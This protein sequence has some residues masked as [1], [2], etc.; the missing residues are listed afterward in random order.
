MALVVF[1]LFSLLQIRKTQAAVSPVK[2]EVV[3]LFADSD[4]C[5]LTVTCRT[6]KAHLNATFECRH[7][8]CTAQDGGELSNADWH[9][10]AF[11]LNSS[12]VCR[13]SN[14]VSEMKE[15]KALQQVCRQHVPKEISS[16]T[17]IWIPLVFG[18]ALG[19]ALIR[20]ALRRRE[21][22][23]TRT[24]EGCQEINLEPNVYGNDIDNGTSPNSTYSLVGHHKGPSETM[25][26]QVLRPAKLPKMLEADPMQVTGQN[27]N[28]LLAL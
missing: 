17:W 22:Q 1:L 27:N 10:A 14:Q 16:F 25:Y 15:A 19:L 24:P 18:L 8:N 3:S 7:A 20:F 9:L 26:A 13:H 23:A 11:I 21:R 5:N 6:N 12:I 28:P 4:S 2:L